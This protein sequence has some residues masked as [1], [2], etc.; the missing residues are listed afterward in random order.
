MSEPKILLEGLGYGE[1]P[2]WHE[3][4]L[5]FANWARA[6]WSRPIPRAVPR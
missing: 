5:W 6:R 4:R 1:S 3:G 2:R